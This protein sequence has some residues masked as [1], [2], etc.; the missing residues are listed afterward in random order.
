MLRVLKLAAVLGALA[1][2]PALAKIDK[3]EFC[4]ANA[5]VLD[6]LVEMRLKGTR[7]NKAVRMLTEGDDMMDETLHF[8]VRQYAG[9]I[10][11]QPRKDAARHDR[12]IFIQSC[13]DQ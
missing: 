7:Q 10:Y 4:S 11:G 6:R 5:D 9:W 13:L 12:A 1:S 8:A 3:D 2:G